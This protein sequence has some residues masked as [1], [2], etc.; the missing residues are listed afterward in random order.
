MVARIL[1]VSIVLFSALNG[2]GQS[3]RFE[4]NSTKISVGERVELKVISDINGSID[5]K[6]PKTFRYGTA[7]QSSMQQQ[8]D[9]SGRLTVQ[10]SYIRDGY[11]DAPGNFV[12]GPVTLK[13]GKKSVTSNTINVVVT[14]NPTISN[15]RGS[16]SFNE[17]ELRKPAFGVVEPNKSKIYEGE[18]VVLQAK[19][20]SKMFPDNMNRYRAYAIDG[21]V[22]NYEIGNPEQIK[23]SKEQ[24]AGFEWN[25]FTFD[26]KVLFFDKK[27]TYKIKPFDINLEIDFG[28]LGVRSNTPLIEVIPLPAN[29]PKDFIGIV[30]DIQL[31]FN[32]QSKPIKKGD[33]LTFKIEL[34]GKGNIQ[35]ALVPSVNFPKGWLEYAAPKPTSRYTFTED[36]AEGSLVY[37]YA[38]QCLEDKPS[39][40]DAITLSYFDPSIGKYKTLKTDP[41]VFDEAGVSMLNKQQSK[42]EAKEM[43]KT[44]LIQNASSETENESPF[45]SPILWLTL[46]SIVAFAFLIGVIGRPK[47][48]KKKFSSL[49][50]N[51]PYIALWSLVETDIEKA[52]KSY[53]L[54][55]KSDA[56]QN[57][58]NAVSKSIS[59]KIELDYREVSTAFM[60]QSFL[61]KSFNQELNQ[62]INEFFYQSQLY[63]YGYGISEEDWKNIHT[64]SMEVIALLK[65]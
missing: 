4:I 25:T 61:E 28:Y 5:I 37:E 24:I 51:K 6:T 15:S 42:D 56:I 7:E 27:G 10:M 34:N 45:K 18:S 43:H 36:G 54:G 31:A 63:R 50:Y 46:A 44:A 8:L 38:Y 20:F 33:I 65:K 13:S 64:L 30:G 58:E 47:F 12:L 3:L 59:I 26:R 62:K 11:F 17:R 14:K 23:S 9:H 53:E 55:D 39:N 57:L 29:K 35:N 60:V 48:R 49:E 22:S 52:F 32:V 16:S 21:S 40:W 41:I 1:I 19:V 2:W